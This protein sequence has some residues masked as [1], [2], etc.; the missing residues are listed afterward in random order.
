MLKRRP[1]LPSTNAQQML[2]QMLQPPRPLLATWPLHCLLRLLHLVIM[3]A[4]ARIIALSVFAAAVCCGTLLFAASVPIE[5]LEQAPAHPVDAGKVNLHHHHHHHHHHH[6]L[7]NP[8]PA[9]PLHLPF[10]AL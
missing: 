4:A 10:D 3:P 2:Q 7:P 9:T 6:P 8:P 5:L 1:R